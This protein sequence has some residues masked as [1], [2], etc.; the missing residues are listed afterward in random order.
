MSFPWIQKEYVLWNSKYGTP[1]PFLILA[2][3]KRIVTGHIDVGDERLD[4]HDWFS[5]T[6]VKTHA[7]SFE[8]GFELRG[9]WADS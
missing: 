1:T 4:Q 9:Y 6:D 8:I 5:L 3:E 7:E 2:Y